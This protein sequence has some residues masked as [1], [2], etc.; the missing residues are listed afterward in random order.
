MME[1]FLALSIQNA[2]LVHYDVFEANQKYYWK[3]YMYKGQL[4]YADENNPF[5]KPIVQTGYYNML[6]TLA[7]A[8]NALVYYTL[9]N[10]DKSGTLNIIYNVGLSILEYKALNEWVEVGLKPNIK[11]TI[12]IHQF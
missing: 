4:A 6:F 3:P 9:H 5:A 1:I 8:G 10:I 7:I 2:A 11:T 12:F